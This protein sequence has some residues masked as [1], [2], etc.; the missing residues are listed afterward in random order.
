MDETAFE[1]VDF[2]A[3]SA[4]ER[5]A[6]AMEAT[7]RK[8]RL[9]EGRY[10][11]TNHELAAN[12]KKEQVWS[13]VTL[14]LG[15]R[16]E[17]LMTLRSVEPTSSVKAPTKD[18]ME[19]NTVDWS[20]LWKQTGFTRPGK[21]AHLLHVST[22]IPLLLELT[23]V[24]IHPLEFTEHRGSKTA[25]ES[26]ASRLAHVAAQ[27][28]SGQPQ[29]SPDLC[30]F[31]LSALNLAL[32]SAKI[33]LPAFVLSGSPSKLLYA[34]VC[35]C[36][37]TEYRWKSLCMPFVP[38]AYAHLQGALLL[39]PQ[40]YQAEWHETFGNDVLPSSVKDQ[41]EV[42]VRLT[43]VLDDQHPTA[44]VN[45]FPS[46]DRHLPFG[47]RYDPVH[48]LSMILDFPLK[49]SGAYVDNPAHTELNW[50]SQHVS[51]TWLTYDVPR[52]PYNIV[53]LPGLR[54]TRVLERTW[55]S[56]LELLYP[57]TE[58]Y[59]SDAYLQEVK[60]AWTTVQ[61]RKYA[62]GISLVDKEDILR[63]I[64][65]IFTPITFAR[66]SK[67]S[68]DGLSKDGIPDIL[69][70]LPHENA[71]PYQ[72][73]LWRIVHELIIV[74]YGEPDGE[75]EH[76]ISSL[77]SFLSVFLVHW[78]R[79]LRWHWEHR[80]ILPHRFDGTSS[81]NHQSVSDQQHEIINHRFN[82]LN[83]KLQMLDCC[84]RRDEHATESNDGDV[85]RWTASPSPALKTS[86]P[87]I[88]QPQTRGTS[89]IG[90][91]IIGTAT[92]MVQSNVERGGN[93]L[94]KIFDSIT[95]EQ[96]QVQNTSE[97]AKEEDWGWHE[98]EEEDH[99]GQQKL[100]AGEDD[101]VFYDTVEDLDVHASSSPPIDVPPSDH[102]A[103]FR[104]RTLSEASATGGLASS[105]GSS[106]DKVQVPP[107]LSLARVDE[108]KYEIMDP[109]KFEGRLK[110]CGD[111][112]LLGTQL[113]L[114][115][116]VTQEAE[117]MTED[118]LE[119][120]QEVFEKLGTSSEAAQI[121]A[122]M[123]SAHLKSGIEFYLYNYLM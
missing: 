93:A 23:P 2:T 14:P 56:V 64:K 40:L 6:A 91:R 7:F 92:N 36:T 85:Q 84:I 67:G 16:S 10:N 69:D 108:E 68:E 31:V 99:H 117:L 35:V 65:R 96:K 51:K 90:K 77:A 20:C 50:Q 101:D 61:G 109:T 78:K 123:Q 119:E 62:D 74:L 97:E 114:W 46:L 32:A 54:Y 60:Q 94:V 106:Y 83:Q 121:R 81:S 26:A 112:K 24:H 41:I 73:L 113:L 82:R 39:L 58:E 43:Y 59:G 17:L 42:A 79:S 75:R 8:W 104:S 63:V 71:I 29:L 103:R 105:L 44:W 53:S 25:L 21:N 3:A 110:P 12:N 18:I 107:S 4:L 87:D 88:E 9:D 66:K 30:K 55:L 47:P 28:T 22:G 100:P 52:H 111:L 86:Q 13:Q 102:I 33:N 5:L 15:A 116:P 80:K 45:A 98:D 1:I 11:L 95:G 120:M 118:V 89:N 115:I 122:K 76:L 70:K 19:D 37:E 38:S 49:P 57:H 27:V 34:G 48:A 72:G